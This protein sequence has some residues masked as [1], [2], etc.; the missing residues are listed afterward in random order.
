MKFTTRDPWLVP[1]NGINFYHHKAVAIKVRKIETL[2]Y[3]LYF[4]Q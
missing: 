3:I 2:K 4:Y 1:K